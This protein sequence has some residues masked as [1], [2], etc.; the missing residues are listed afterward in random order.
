MYKFPEVFRR[1]ERIVDSSRIHGFANLRL[2]FSNWAGG[3]RKDT[4]RQ[5][6]A[7][8]IEA[9]QIG[10]P[11]SIN[12]SRRETPSMVSAYQVNHSKGEENRFTS[13]EIP[14][15]EGSALLATKLS[16]VNVRNRRLNDER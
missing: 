8:A 13:S 4:S 2:A 9:Q 11:V 10:I 3:R 14:E 16:L 1:F 12:D 15:P 6:H 5:R 7:P